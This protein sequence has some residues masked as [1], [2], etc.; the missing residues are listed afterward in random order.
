MLAT[1]TQTTLKLGKQALKN[2][3]KITYHS[4]EGTGNYKR[5]LKT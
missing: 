4:L 1:S 3:F 5:T 2:Y